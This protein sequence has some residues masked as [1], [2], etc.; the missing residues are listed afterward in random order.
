MT[1][2][3]TRQ[4]STCCGTYTAWK[5]EPWFALPH[6]GTPHGGS[7]G[8]ALPQF[9]GL[10][11]SQRRSALKKLA[12]AT[13]KMKEVSLFYVVEADMLPKCLPTAFM[14]GQ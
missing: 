11:D 3:T 8:L 6:S 10:T 14:L 13:K 4:Q 2:V 9:T 1:L 12:A 5:F 7:R